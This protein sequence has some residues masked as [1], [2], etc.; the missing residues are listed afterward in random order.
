MQDL[1]FDG[2][3]A[4]HHDGEHR[5]RLDP[6]E[7]RGADPHGVGIGA[8][9]D[10]GMTRELREKLARLVEQIFEGTM[11]RR[12]EV[13]DRRRWPTG[14]PPAAVKWSTKYRYPWSVGI[15]PADVCGWARNPSRSSWVMSLRTVALDTPKS[16][17]SVTVWDATGCAVRTYSSTTALSTVARRSAA[18]A[19]GA[20]RSA[21]RIRR[22]WPVGQH[23]ECTDC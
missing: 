14:S 22:R 21:R 12:E 23:L 17:E 3:V 4:E 10:R 1:A 15:R 8:D 9:H 7:L 18:S 11:G 20:S 16:R 6:D 2:A 13:G 19:R 5:A